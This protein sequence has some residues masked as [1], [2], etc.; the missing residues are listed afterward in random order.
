MA[1]RPKPTAILK[2]QGSSRANGRAH[3][4]ELPACDRDAPAYLCGPALDEWDR[5]AGPLIDSGVLTIV[6]RACLAACCA[7]Y[8]RWIEAEAKV[9]ELGHVI[10]TPNG[11]LQVSP[12]V[13]IA[14]EALRQYRAFAIELGLS[15]SSR[16]RVRAT[17]PAKD[18]GGFDKFLNKS[19]H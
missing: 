9:R 7:A 16:S 12:Y 13:S 15:P 5:L 1:P 10:E 17:K 2:L 6:D 14:N 18:D 11:S 3:E 8:G 4:P 19:K